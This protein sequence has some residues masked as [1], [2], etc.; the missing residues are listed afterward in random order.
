MYEVL[1]PTRC[2]YL[3][4]QA[5]GW[6]EKVSLRVE[7]YGYKEGKNRVPKCDVIENE[8]VKLWDLLRHSE[9]KTS[10]TPTRQKL[11]IWGRLSLRY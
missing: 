6:S 4:V 10:K 8:I 7:L 3:R 2:R 5:L 1:N 11:A 9:R